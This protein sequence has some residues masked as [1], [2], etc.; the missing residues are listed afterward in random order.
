MRYAEESKR[1]SGQVGRAVKTR[2]ANGPAWDC[3]MARE[4]ASHASAI[5]DASWSS[6][7]WDAARC[8]PRPKSAGSSCENSS[9]GGQL[10]KKVG[11]GRHI[12]T[13]MGEDDG[14]AFKRCQTTDGGGVGELLQEAIAEGPVT[15]SDSAQGVDP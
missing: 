3:N 10:S 6:R 2:P 5:S 1:I 14:C 11:P 4:A 7:T 8:Q 15:A 12:E 9:G 13:V